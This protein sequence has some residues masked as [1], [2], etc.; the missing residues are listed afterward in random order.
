MLRRKGRHFLAATRFETPKLQAPIDVYY[1]INV[2]HQ[3]DRLSSEKTKDFNRNTLTAAG[4]IEDEY[5]EYLII[6]SVICI[7]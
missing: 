2:F 1:A 6:H 5:D 4:Q 7:D 3:L